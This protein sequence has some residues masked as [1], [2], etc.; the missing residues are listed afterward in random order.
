[1][2]QGLARNRS[3]SARHAMVHRTLQH[4]AGIYTDPPSANLRR[5]VNQT[6]LVNVVS[7][8]SANTTYKSHLQNW[9]CFLNHFRFK[10]VVYRVE[11]GV[12]ADF[13]RNSPRAHVLTYPDALFWSVVAGKRAP[14][15]VHK[16]HGD[17]RG[18]APSFQH[19]GALVMLVP[20]LEV[21]MHGFNA[22]YFDVDVA[23]LLDPIPFMVRG[24]ADISVSAELRQCHWPS[25]PARRAHIDWARVEPN[26]GTMHV[27][28]NPRT[29]ALYRA[30]LTAIVD[31][32]I[33][34][35]QKALNFF[36]LGVRFVS[37][38]NW[39]A[40]DRSERHAVASG[41]PTYHSVHANDTVDPAA[42]T[43]CVYSEYLFQNGKISM[44]CI[45][46]RGGQGRCVD[47]QGTWWCSVGWW[48]RGGKQKYPF[49]S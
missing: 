19:F 16:D 2:W 31:I 10:A 4:A 23:L 43:F 39:D 24:T 42:P 7:Y 29:V 35:D 26:T 18:M 36:K 6:V 21:L 14:M 45:A 25:H 34:N 40:G 49:L 38:C 13:M 20:I 3:D 5:A 17:Y 44:R 48:R 37:D 32:N 28:A 30:W 11:P 15:L 46:G 33:L 41:W 8:T 12:A 27:R 47:M 22:I 1:M 9:F